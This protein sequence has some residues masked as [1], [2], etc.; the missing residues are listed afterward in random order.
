MSVSRQHHEV[1]V[2]HMLASLLEAPYTDVQSIL[3]HFGIDTGRLQKALN[4]TLDQLRTGNTGRP[5]FSPTLVGWFKDAWILGSLTHRDSK[6]RSGHMIHAMLDGGMRICGGDY[7]TLLE[8]IKKSELSEKLDEITSDSSEQGEM[9]EANA[10]AGGGSPG[11]TA[12]TGDS[13]LEK[14]CTNLTQR[15]RDG[16]IDPIFGRDREIRQMVDILAR[17]RKNNP[18]IVGEAGVGK[19]ALVEGLA[20][21]H[22]HRATCSDV[23]KRRRSPFARY[24]SASSRRQREGRVREPPEERHRPR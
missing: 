13:A 20:L 5:V 22:R 9:Q 4:G 17:R 14:F 23:L 16:H 12:P 18:I 3:K 8:Q 10:A 24:G 19:T 11:G 7:A 21:K 15:A 2:E 1:T 6:V